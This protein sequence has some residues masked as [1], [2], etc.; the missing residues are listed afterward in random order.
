MYVYLLKLNDGTGVKIG[1]SNN[2]IN[3]AQSLP[4]DFDLE[5]S[6]FYFIGE[7]CFNIE[8]S[9]H[10]LFDKKRINVGDK[11]GFT[12]FFELEVK[13]YAESHL[14]FVGYEKVNLLDEILEVEDK[15]VEDEISLIMEKIANRTEAKRVNDYGVTQA[16]FCE[17]MSIPLSSY[18][19]FKSNHILSLRKMVSILIS[20]GKIDEFLDLL[21]PE[22]GYSRK[23]V[24]NASVAY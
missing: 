4:Y 12:E 21:S 17:K 22:N 11:D 15:K 16:E 20:F 8:S 6:S 19:H 13:E 2:P 5:S 7:Q 9:L 3:R 24:N 10:K 1:K 18:K 14:D 23:R